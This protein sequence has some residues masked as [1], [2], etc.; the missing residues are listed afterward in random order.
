MNKLD[1][2]DEIK[3]ALGEYAEDFDVD[4]IFEE[5]YQ[6]DGKG[7]FEQRED[8]DFYEVAARYDVSEEA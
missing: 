5:C 3:T 4:G 8:V 2:I 1:C 7:G 6:Y